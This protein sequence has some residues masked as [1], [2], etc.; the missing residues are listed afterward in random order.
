LKTNR[1]NIFFE[2]PEHGWLPVTLQFNDEELELDVSDVPVDPVCEL[3]SA[4][5]DISE[6]RSKKITWFLEPVECELEFTVTGDFTKLEVSLN[7]NNSKSLEHSIE[8]ET[9]HMLL[10]FWRA[11]RK[12][13]TFDIKNHWEVPIE[14]IEKLTSKINEIKN[15]K[16][17]LTNQR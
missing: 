17:I 7:E 15:S 16:I 5:L 2:N 4:L 9:N 8:I 13:E 6:S 1:F 12:F 14:Y 10:T 3:I 11:L